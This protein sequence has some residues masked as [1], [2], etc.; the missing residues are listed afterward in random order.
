LRWK[1]YDP[2]PTRGS[3]EVILKVCATNHSTKHDENNMSAVSITLHG[4]QPDL[5]AQLS[6]WAEER[7]VEIQET[8]SGNLRI[9]VPAADIQE[10]TRAL[11]GL[12][13]LHTASVGPGPGEKRPR[14]YFGQALDRV[15]QQAGTELVFCTPARV[16]ESLANR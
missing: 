2:R 9:E 6:E 15:Q 13:A 8:P 3:Q 14:L 16:I 4:E 12:P 1:D 5:R 7:G 11:K 10:V